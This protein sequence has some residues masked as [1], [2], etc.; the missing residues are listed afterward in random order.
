MPNTLARGVVQ[1]SSAR[2]AGFGA[3]GLTL[4]SIR[5]RNRRIDLDVLTPFVKGHPACDI[6]RRSQRRPVYVL[7]RSNGLGKQQGKF[8][9]CLVRS[10]A[11][12]APISDPGRRTIE[13]VLTGIEAV[14][15]QVLRVPFGHP[16]ELAANAE[17]QTHSKI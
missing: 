12:P 16:S 17:L 3:G 13:N 11:D 6:L 10:V 8:P 4:V 1:F 7:A 15:P 14:A 5:H 2:G 9:F